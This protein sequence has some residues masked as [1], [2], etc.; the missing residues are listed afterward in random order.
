MVREELLREIE[1]NF[2]FLKDKIL[3]I[4]LFGSYAREE[5]RRSD[6]DVCIVVGKRDVK[7]IW[8]ELLASEVTAKYDVNIF[9]LLPLRLKG[10]VIENSKVVWCKDLGELSYYLFK[11]RKIWEDQKL[12]LR[13][14][15]FEIFHWLE[16]NAFKMSSSVFSSSN[17]SLMLQARITWKNFQG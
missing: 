10:E 16:K 14:L 9:E 1:E 8:E 7:E 17:L 4:L 5:D 6:I 12:S 11:F 13:K 3:G 15:G 2:E